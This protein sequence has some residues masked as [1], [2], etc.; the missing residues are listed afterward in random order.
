MQGDKIKIRVQNMDYFITGGDFK[1]LL[2][3]VKSLPNR[4]Y[5]GEQ[6]LW[7]VDASPEMVRGQIE[8]SGFVLEGGTPVPPDATP[9]APPS[10]D[11]IKI[12]TDNIRAVVTGAP[13][14]DLL[15]AIKALPERR[16]DG[17][18]KRW[19]LSGS[20][21]ELNSY[22]ENKQ[23]QLE[24]ITTIT[25]SPPQPA[26][27]R[28]PTM[29]T[30]PPLPE[31]MPYFSE[32]ELAFM[33][34]PTG[35]AEASPPPAPARTAQIQHNHRDQIR[36]MIGNRRLVIVGGT[37]QEMLAAVKNVPGRRFDGGSKQWLLPDDIESVQQHFNSKG[38]RLEEN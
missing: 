35:A 24:Q 6:K 26:S 4:R 15:A 2:A 32:E 33:N 29:D 1:T 7:L 13:F 8:N 11:Q 16:F 5:V 28:L 12:E 23:L 22:F 14:S 37:F 10:K 34:E 25:Q 30:P 31:D 21:P 3:V 18:S 27:Q 19:I 20:L 17:N 38:F 9:A 36:V